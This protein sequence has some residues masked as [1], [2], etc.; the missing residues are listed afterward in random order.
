MDGRLIRID[1]IVVVGVVGVLVERD[2]KHR[3]PGP[4]PEEGTDQRNDQQ[5]S[6][7]DSKV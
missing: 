4:D 7:H 5:L 6:F 1:V 2:R 3:N